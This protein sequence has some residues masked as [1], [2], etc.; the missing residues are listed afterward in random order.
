MI[1]FASVSI[2]AEA[3]FSRPSLFAN[4]SRQRKLINIVRNGAST[5]TS[6]ASQ[7][8]RMNKHQQHAVFGNFQKP[9]TLVRLEKEEIVDMVQA[10]K[11][12]LPAIGSICEIE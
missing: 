12:N 11:A 8:N 6:L 3:H 10:E 2:A 9:Q 5:Q 7:P 1:R 4:E